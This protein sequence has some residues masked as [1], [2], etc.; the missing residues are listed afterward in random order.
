MGDRFDRSGLI[1]T[2]AALD[3]EPDPMLRLMAMVPPDAERMRGLAAR[4]KMSR[5][6][7]DRLVKWA[8]APV[9]AIRRWRSRRLTGCFT[10]MARIRSSTGSA[11]RWSRRAARTETDPSALTEA[12][13][14]SRHLA[15]ALGWDTP[16]VSLV[17]GRRSD[18][19]GA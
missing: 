6:E 5:A 1:A 15:R 7:T 18:C 13:G 3:W 10:A 11:C 16:G 9:V 12:A 4:L 19:P 8:A 14:H 2:E 17:C